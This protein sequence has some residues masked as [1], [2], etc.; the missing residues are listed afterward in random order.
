[1][2]NEEMT[3]QQWPRVHKEIILT[4]IFTTVEFD[5]H[6]KKLLDSG[7]YT[8]E[9]AEEVDDREEYVVGTPMN[10][11]NPAAAGSCSSRKR[12]LGALKAP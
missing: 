2:L 10:E 3:V 7:H 8:A 9:G 4:T 5:T 11:R 6:T 1:M 12:S